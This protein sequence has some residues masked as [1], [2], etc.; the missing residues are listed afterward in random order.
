MW[1]WA[2]SYETQE[3]LRRCWRE[4]EMKRTGAEKTPTFAVGLG[5]IEND[6]PSATSL[7]SFDDSVRTLSCCGRPHQ[8]K[9]NRKEATAPPR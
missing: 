2:A 6:S 8:L 3:G 5:G 9:G 1:Q 7:G 4:E